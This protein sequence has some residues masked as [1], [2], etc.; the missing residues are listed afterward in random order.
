M[1]TINLRIALN[2]RL[3]HFRQLVTAYVARVLLG[4]KMLVQHAQH[5]LQVSLAVVKQ[6]PHVKSARKVFT[7]TKQEHRTVCPA[8][9]ED[10]KIVQEQLVA[11][12]VPKI[13]HR[14]SQTVL[15]PVILVP[16]EELQKTGVLCVRNVWRGS[17]KTQRPVGKRRV[18]FVPLATT[19]IHQTC[20]RVSSAQLV[21]L[22][23][24]RSKRRALNAVP[25]N[26]MML[27]VRFVAK[28]VAIQRT[29]VERE[30]TAVASIV[31]LDGRPKTAVR[32]VSRAAR[33]RLALGA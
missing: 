22:N 33:V 17:L 31:Q 8:Y 2:A 16:Q 21:M 5:A 4:K 15:H 28:R 11:K 3:E 20:K 14:R 19:R 30:E 29:L 13:R 1:C 26:S 32:N 25:V 24:L 9:P 7:K 23:R 10:T 18:R 27:P 12:S 6:I